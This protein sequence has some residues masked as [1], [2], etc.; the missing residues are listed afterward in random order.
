VKNV[1]KKVNEIRC[2]ISSRDKK[3]AEKGEKA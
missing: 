3:A 1:C 2:I